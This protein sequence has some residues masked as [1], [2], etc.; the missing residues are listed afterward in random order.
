MKLE[1]APSQK[2]KATAFELMMQR[3]W[4]GGRLWALID[5]WGRLGIVIIDTLGRTHTIILCKITFSSIT[6]Q[7]PTTMIATPQ[8]SPK[9][10]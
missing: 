10:P 4:R 8:T 2:A 6:T 1:D 3:K 5:E 9:V 7:S